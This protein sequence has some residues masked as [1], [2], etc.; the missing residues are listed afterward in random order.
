M[1]LRVLMS[2]FIYIN[3]CKFGCPYYTKSD[4]Q[5]LRLMYVCMLAGSKMPRL[6]SLANRLH[7]Q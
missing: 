7:L 5:S 4:A 6:P 3:C 2:H 1:L